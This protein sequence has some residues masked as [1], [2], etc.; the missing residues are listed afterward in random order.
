[1]HFQMRR[2]KWVHR[3]TANQVELGKVGRCLRSTMKLCDRT[4]FPPRDIHLDWALNHSE[5][6]ARPPWSL[7]GSDVSVFVVESLGFVEREVQ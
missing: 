2:L 1:M 7:E 5:E 4:R 3:K 6:V